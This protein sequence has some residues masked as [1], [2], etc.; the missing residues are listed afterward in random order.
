MAIPLL[1]AGQAKAPVPGWLSCPQPARGPDR[2]GQ[3][4]GPARQGDRSP[5]RARPETA[6][7]QAGGRIHLQDRL[8]CLGRASPQGTQGRP[9]EHAFPD[10]AHLQQGRAAH[11]GKDVD[12]RHSSP[13][14]PG[15]PGGDREAQGVHHRRES[16]HLVQPDVPICAGHRRGTG[17][18]PGRGP[19]RGGRAQA[20]GG[21]QPLP[22]PARDA[23]VP[24]E[25]PALQPPWLADPAWR[26]ATVPDRGAHRRTA[27][28]R[29]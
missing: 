6:R 26:P 27:V 29:T 10:P 23:R 1:L 2:A 19:G 12:L 17:S 9:S 11:S 14:A 22:A 13:P 21:P 5:G 18:Q 20:P 28:G 25:A 16:P 7:G 3:G 15:R 24:S 8:R 4:P